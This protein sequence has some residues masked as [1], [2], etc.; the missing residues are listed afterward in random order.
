MSSSALPESLE[1]VVGA[2]VERVADRVAKRFR[3]DLGGSLTRP[4][5]VT[6]KESPLDETTFKRLAKTGELATYRVGRRVVTEL[7]RCGAVDTGSA[8]AGEGECGRGPVGPGVD[9]R[10][11]LRRA[12]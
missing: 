3:E 2:L 5:W 10:Y 4:R 12:G 7:P 8:G 11:T 1:P 6:A 9:G